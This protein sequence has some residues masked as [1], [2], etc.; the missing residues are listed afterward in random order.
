MAK[1]SQLSR[2]LQYIA[3]MSLGVFWGT[4]SGSVLLFNII[5][6]GGKSLKTVP[7]PTAPAILS[8]PK[9]GTHHYIQANGIKLHYVTKGEGKPV[10]FLH[11]FPE[12]WYTWRSQLTE[13]SSKYKVIAVDMRGYGD[14]ERPTSVT[15]YSLDK[16]VNDIYLFIRALNYDKVSLVSHDWGGIVAWQF[17][18]MHPEVLDKLVVLNCPHPTS[19]QKNLSFS[20]FLKSWYIFMFQMPIIPETLFTSYDYRQLYGAF[21]G[22]KMGAIR[23]DAYTS[24]DIEVYKYAFSRPGAFTAAVNYYRNLFS[25]WNP[26]LPRRAI[27]IPTLVIWGEKDAALGAPLLKGTERFVPN[28]TIKKLPNASHWVHHDEPEVVNNYLQEFISTGKV[29]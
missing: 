14:S 18:Q 27:D 22:K 20:Q 5:I 1:P 9:W 21:K 7:R 24:Q 17:A 26:I 6:S 16:L 25:P 10:V 23:P 15:A 11:G 13:L 29:N 19:F 28:L 3:V 4:V 12:F 8:D 2:W